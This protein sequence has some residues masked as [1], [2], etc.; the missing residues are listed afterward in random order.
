VNLC[1]PRFGPIEIRFSICR[2]GKFSV[3]NPEV[4][5]RRSNH[6]IDRFRLEACH[7]RHA[8]AKAQIEFGHAA[9]NSTKSKVQPPSFV[10]LI[11][12]P[13]ENGPLTILPGSP[14]LKASHPGYVAKAPFRAP[15]VVNQTGSEMESPASP[16]PQAALRLHAAQMTTRK[17]NDANSFSFP[18]TG[19]G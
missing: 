2:V 4:V 16:A 9:I 12:Q 18:P 7:P 19:S 6:E 14:R 13:R 1:G 10:I 3:P 17:D 8:I 5:R 11:P 15:S